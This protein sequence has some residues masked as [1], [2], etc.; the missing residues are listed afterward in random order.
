[1]IAP[2]VNI[3]REL[4]TTMNGILGS[5]QGSKHAAPDLS[6][7]IESLMN[8]LDEYHVYDKLGRTFSD[9][10]DS[11]TKDVVAEGLKA[12]SKPLAAYNKAFAILQQRC[13][14]QPVIVGRPG[15]AHRPSAPSGTAT[16]ASV[17]DATLASVPA[18]QTAG[19]S[20]HHPLASDEDSDPEEVEEE[21]DELSELTNILD[22]E[23]GEGRDP[24]ADQLSLETEEDVAF[25]MDGDDDLDNI[26]SDEEDE[27]EDEDDLSD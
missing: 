4:A 21:D 6:D 18:S 5:D 7:D 22:D 11:E 3:L 25:D 23:C 26:G 27:G 20:S 17:S 2:C 15:H 10:E 9:S 1:M 13:R 8:N 24:D 16:S 14:M 19:S 12:L